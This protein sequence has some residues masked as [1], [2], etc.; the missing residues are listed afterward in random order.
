MVMIMAAIYFHRLL[1]HDL[2]H[3]AVRSGHQVA[4]AE[5]FPGREPEG[6]LLAA[7]QDGVEMI[8]VPMEMQPPLHLDAVRRARDLQLGA[9]LDHPWSARR[10][11]AAPSASRPV[12]A[13]K[14]QRT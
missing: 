4:V 7:V 6:R 14:H 3:A 9:D 2:E 10:S 13:A 5:Y 1:R 8:A 12:D 11:R